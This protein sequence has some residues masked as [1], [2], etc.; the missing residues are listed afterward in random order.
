MK[1]IGQQFASRHHSEPLHKGEPN[2]ADAY[3]LEELVYAIFGKPRRLATY[4]RLRDSGTVA[5][6]ITEDAFNRGEPRPELG[7]EAT[8]K[9][10]F[11]L[12]N[13]I[14]RQY[15]DGL[16]VPFT[17]MYKAAVDYLVNAGLWPVYLT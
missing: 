3:L 17:L 13:F 2:F 9:C 15:T 10:L 7:R 14:N 16:C 5:N 11:Y 4:T 1:W 8:V 6:L 12:G